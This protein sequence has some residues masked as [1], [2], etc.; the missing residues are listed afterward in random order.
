MNI[1]KIL[2]LT[3]GTAMSSWGTIHFPEGNWLIEFVINVESTQWRS[4][5]WSPCKP[6]PSGGFQA[7]QEGQERLMEDLAKIDPRFQAQMICKE[8]VSEDQVVKLLVQ[9]LRKVDYPLSLEEE[10]TKIRKILSICHMP[11]L[12]KK[13]S[14]RRRFEVE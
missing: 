5:S 8:D 10:T 6:A 9:E 13:P 12:A 3:P 4:T 1:C 14:P 2:D 7:I 11:S